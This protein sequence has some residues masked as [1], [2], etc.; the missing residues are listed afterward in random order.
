VDGRKAKAFGR[1]P[2]GKTGSRRS[3]APGI[4]ITVDYCDS[5]RMHLIV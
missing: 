1:S 5:E 2:E 4:L 3:K